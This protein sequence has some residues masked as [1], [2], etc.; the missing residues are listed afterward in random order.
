MRA[1][2]YTCDRCKRALPNGVDVF[3]LDASFCKKERRILDLCG[4][5]CGAF[6]QWLDG[7]DKED[8]G[9]S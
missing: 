5:C 9:G 4:D 3:M 7:H 6:E 2:I 8:Y 1:T